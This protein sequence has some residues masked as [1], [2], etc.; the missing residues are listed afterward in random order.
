MVNF[1]SEREDKDA[2][3]SYLLNLAG[4]MQGGRSFSPELLNELGGIPLPGGQ[5]LTTDGLNEIFKFFSDGGDF[6]MAQGWTQQ[7]LDAVAYLAQSFESFGQLEQAKDVLKY[8]CFV[9]HLHAPYWLKFAELQARLGMFECAND[10]L[11]M[12]YHFSEEPWQFTLASAEVHL[13]LGNLDDCLSAINATDVHLSKKPQVSEQFQ[14]RLSGVR[15][16]LVRR[17]STQQRGEV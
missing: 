15:S 16:A 4:Q 9:K 10:S 8:L 6:A 14:S 11:G 7:E 17:Q 3:A 2:L 5:S 1:Y 12:G 13:H